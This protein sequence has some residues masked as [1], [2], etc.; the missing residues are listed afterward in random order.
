M[1]EERLG[2]ARAR[3]VEASRA[4]QKR[5]AATAT[6]VLQKMRTQQSERQEGGGAGTPARTGPSSSIINEIK[7]KIS[8]D[9]TIRQLI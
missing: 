5:R 7:G 4:G 3:T 2:E 9:L 8:S 6:S 1:R